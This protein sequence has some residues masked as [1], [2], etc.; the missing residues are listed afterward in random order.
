MANDKQAAR[1]GRLFS[2]APPP[3]GARYRDDLMDPAAEAA[4][5]ARIRALPL[6][7]F[8]FQRFTA[9]RRAASFGWHYRFDGGGLERGAPIPDWLLPAR[10]EAAAFAGLP[11]EALEQVLVLDYPRGAGIGWHRDRPVFGKVVGM[12]LG[13]PARLRFRKRLEREFA[14]AELT[15]APRS[16]YLLD[17][18][19]RDEWEHSIPPLDAPRL[20]L[21]FRTLRN[22]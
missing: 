1:Q 13:A 7:P 18:P 9:L 5:A 22:A 20:A 4:L 2:Y 17:G 11:A 16:A 10:A 21:T 14:R 15:L 19:A 6:E 8:R 12:S 3:D